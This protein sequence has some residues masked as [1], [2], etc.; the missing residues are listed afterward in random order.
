[1]L[2]LTGG[3]DAFVQYW[4]WYSN[5]Q[6]DSPHAD[7]F[8]V[9]ISNNSGTTW[10]PLETVGPAI[11]SDGGWFFRAFH[12]NDFVAP[13]ATVRVRFT[14]EDAGS[15]SIVEAAIDDFVAYVVDCSGTTP[16][17]GDLDGD[18]TIGLGDLSVLLS[19]F[20]TVSGAEPEDGD[21]TGDGAVDLGDLSALLSVFGTTCP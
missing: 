17:P 13:N 16:C 4:R 15:G 14:A 2:N 11:E 21:L 8:R 20:G 3:S 7:T 1:M 12:V 5:N 18:G 19:N 6:G 10:V 9:E